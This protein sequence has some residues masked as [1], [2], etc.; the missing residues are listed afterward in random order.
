MSYPQRSVPS[1]QRSHPFASPRP[2]RPPVSQHAALKIVVGSG[3][4]LLVVGLG[5]AVG[6]GKKAEANPA[7]APTVT[8]KTEQAAAERPIGATGRTGKTAASGPAT[9]AGP[10]SYRVGEDLVPGTYETGGPTASDVPPCSWARARGSGREPGSG[11]TKGASRGP[12]RVTVY[13]GQTF[14]THGCRPWTKTG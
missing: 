14:E 9:T 10:G 13:D 2:V 4:A 12:A 3:C 8:G 1:G 5:I 7:S 6:G 11:L